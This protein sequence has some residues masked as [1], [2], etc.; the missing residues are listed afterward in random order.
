MYLDSLWAIVDKESGKIY[1]GISTQN[2]Y[3]SKGRAEARLRERYKRYGGDWTERYE[4]VELKL[5][6][7]EVTE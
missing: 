7:S 2:A 1:A 6:K 5:P 4:V 3:T